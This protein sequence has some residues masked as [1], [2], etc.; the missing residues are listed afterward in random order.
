MIGKF[1]LKTTH[2]LLSVLLLIALF[3]S[4]QTSQAKDAF[5]E[6]THSPGNDTFDGISSVGLYGTFS[7]N[8]GILSYGG[9]QMTLFRDSSTSSDEGVA[10][11]FIGE[12]FKGPIS[13]FFEIGTDAYGFLVLLL[14]EDNNDNDESCA[15]EQRCSIDAYFRFGIRFYPTKELSL[16]VYYENSNFGD[17]H[18]HLTGSHHYTGAS[19]GFSF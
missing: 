3:A 5:I 12:A 16:G 18:T 17:S 6:L 1:N 11:M 8:F 4:P 9:V 2:A 14:N 19:L 13:P 7:K 15:S 10:R